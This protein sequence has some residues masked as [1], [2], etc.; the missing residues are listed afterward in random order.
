MKN[1]MGFIITLFAAF[2]VL[3]AVPIG[4]SSFFGYDVYDD[5]NII[6][7]TNDYHEFDDLLVHMTEDKDNE[8]SFEVDKLWGAFAMKYFTTEENGVYSF[9]CDLEESK[10]DF[11]V[12]LVNMDSN[13]VVASIYDEDKDMNSVT[14]ELA[15][16]NYA[17]K[18]VG[19]R[20]RAQGKFHIN[21]G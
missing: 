19:R 1:R 17:V 4:L 3:V 13:E 14:A 10:G 11:K 9:D 6:A 12:V 20:A 18:A 8:W 15:P 5:D 7:R 21:A 2:A 16:A